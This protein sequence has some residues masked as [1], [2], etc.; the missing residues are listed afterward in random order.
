M[1]NLSLYKATELATFERFIDVETGE[2]D[3]AGFESANIALAEKQRAVAA[4]TR[5]LQVRKSML[6]AAKDEIIKPIDAELSRIDKQEQRNTEYLFNNMRAAGITSIEALDGSFKATIKNN[7]P[8]VVIDDESAIP[9]DYM[10]QPKPPAPKPDKT[11]IKKAISDGYTVAGAHIE[12]GKR[13]EI[14]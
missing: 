8:S 14:K 13:L 1:S 4:Y 5:N 2:F 10:S 3:E 11:L 6:L 7:P 9:A 12:Q